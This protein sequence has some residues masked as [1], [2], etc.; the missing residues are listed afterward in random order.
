MK[1]DTKY[2]WIVTNI[3]LLLIY[4]RLIG[5]QNLKDAENSL[6]GLFAIFVSYLDPVLFF[7]VSFS[8]FDIDKHFYLRDGFFGFFK[9][10]D[11]KIYSKAMSVL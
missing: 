8:S 1:K 7:D 11:E 6:N 5:I 10:L 2:Y 9:G 4:L 3:L